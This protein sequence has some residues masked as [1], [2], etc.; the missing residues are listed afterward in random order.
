M[1]YDFVAEEMVRY[2]FILILLM[3]SDVSDA[4]IISFSDPT[5]EFDNYYN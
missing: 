4:G 1:F 5:N 2:H 3:L